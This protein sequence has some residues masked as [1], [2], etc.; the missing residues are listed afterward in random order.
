M[1]RMGLGYDRLKELNPSIIYV[2]QSGFGDAGLWGQTRAYG[3]SAA[4]LSGISDM[5]GLPEPFP[6]A[7]IGYS[8]LDWF[9]AYNAATAMVAALY[10]REISGKGC[11]IDASQ[12]EIGIY[13]TGTAVLDHSVNGRRW[14]RYGNRSPYKQAA[15]HGAYRARGEDR[16]IAIAAFTEQHWRSVA[17]VLG[18]PEWVDDER[19]AD[20]AARLVNQDELDALVNE[21][22]QGHDRFVLMDR[23]QAV[24]VPAGVCQTSQD[25]YETDPQLA[26]LGWLVELEQT[27]IGRWPVKDLPTQMSETPSYI[28]GRFDRS[29]PSYDHDTDEVLSRILHL[30]DAEIA[31]ARRQGALSSG[32]L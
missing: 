13:L 3:P 2:Q 10:R 22:T 32:D 6:P 20:L 5:S 21:A 31:D 29:G 27:T 23:L 30:S 19:F 26:H 7:G 12:G 18:H 8:Y 17:D 1:D 9:G 24:G 15:P 16:W 25:R 28:G 14:S 11:H 4:A